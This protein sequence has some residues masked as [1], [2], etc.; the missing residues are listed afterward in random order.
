MSFVLDVSVW[1]NVEAPALRRL[2]VLAKVRAGV[3]FSARDVFVGAMV[4]VDWAESCAVDVV[5]TPSPCKSFEMSFS[6]ES[7][8]SWEGSSES[9]A[10]SSLAAVG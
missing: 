9:E 3:V 4:A 8:V 10:V 1:L 6:V 2:A 5:D 7:P